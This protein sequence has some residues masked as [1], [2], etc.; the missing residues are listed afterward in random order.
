MSHNPFAAKDFSKRTLKAL[1]AKSLFVV[2]CSCINADGD[3]AYL[4]S[5]GRTV[6]FLDL[7]DISAS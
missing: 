6:S 4:L 1:A 5:D 2:S 3:V 7:L